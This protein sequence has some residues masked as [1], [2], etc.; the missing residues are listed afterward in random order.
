[1]VSGLCKTEV[2]LEWGDNQTAN[3]LVRTPVVVFNVARGTLSEEDVSRAD[4]SNR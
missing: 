4:G 2:E 1:M 3:F